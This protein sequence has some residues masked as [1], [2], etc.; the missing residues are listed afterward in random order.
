MHPWLT[1]SWLRILLFNSATVLRIE[2]SLV[3]FFFM[4]VRV[5]WNYIHFE[6]TNIWF[7]V[8]NEVKFLEFRKYWNEMDKIFWNPLFWFDFH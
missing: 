2:A 5:A 7:V 1:V 4:Q 6:Q 8:E 3:R